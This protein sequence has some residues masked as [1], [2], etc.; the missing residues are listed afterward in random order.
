MR[1]HIKKKLF[2]L[3][4]VVLSITLCAT[5]IS[6]IGVGPSSYSVIYEP[7]SSIKISFTGVNRE[8]ADMPVKLFSDGELSISLPI[9]K[10]ILLASNEQSLEAT[11]DI[12]KTFS[13]GIHTSLVY[14][15]REVNPEDFL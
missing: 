10:V 4:A 14:I 9:T 5:S 15:E 7:N 1:P 11:L 3:L 12:N 13:P 6:A 8:D 2:V